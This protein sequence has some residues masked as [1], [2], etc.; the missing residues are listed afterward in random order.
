MN[1]KILLNH[2]IC[3]KGTVWCWEGG[4]FCKGVEL[5]KGLGEVGGGVVCYS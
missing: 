2:M 4:G 3:L 5:A 1:S